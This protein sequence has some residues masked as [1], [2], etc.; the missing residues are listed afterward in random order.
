M[1]STRFEA[2]RLIGKGALL[3]LYFLSKLRVRVSV[4]VFSSSNQSTASRRVS[5]SSRMR[6]NGTSHRPGLDLV[7]LHVPP[8]AMQ[9]WAIPLSMV[10]G[11]RLFVPSAEFSSAS[12]MDESYVKLKLARL[13][14]VLWSNAN[15]GVRNPR[16]SSRGTPHVSF[17]QSTAPMIWSLVGVF[18]C[19]Y[20]RVAISWPER[21]SPA[22][23]SHF[24]PGVPP[25]ACAT[26]TYHV[27][28]RGHPSIGE[29]YLPRGRYRSY[30]P[31]VMAPSMERRTNWGIVERDCP[32]RAAK[33]RVG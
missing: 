18:D 29:R 20:V 22:T 11:H 28:L 27:A 30:A 10:Y 13:S 24:V 3:P 32:L 7:W 15:R 2:E 17:S 12:A 14:K 23:M 21:R 19:P 26:L 6:H 1:L 16:I 9:L 8:E 4:T 33:S 31:G 5:S 25:G